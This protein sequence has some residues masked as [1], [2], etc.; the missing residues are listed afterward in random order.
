MKTH[1]DYVYL[2]HLRLNNVF[3]FSMLL[4]VKGLN[5]FKKIL[6]R[7]TGVR[8]NS[9]PEQ[10]CENGLIRTCISSLKVPVLCICASLPIESDRHRNI[11][12][13]LD[14]SLDPLTTATL[15]LVGNCG[16]KYR[17]RKK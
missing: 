15:I 13:L 5:H 11:L 3:S 1:F 16:T 14:S 17:G 9:H 10:Y 2:L 4:N 8:I 7:L 6:K 12:T